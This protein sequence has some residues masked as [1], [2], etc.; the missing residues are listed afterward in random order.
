MLKACVVCGNPSD[1]GRCPAHRINRNGSTRRSRKQRQRIIQRDGY[2]CQRCGRYL[3]GRQDTHADHIVP[4]ANG[5]TWD[6]SNMQTL[7]AECNQTKGTM[8]ADDHHVYPV[9]DL[10]EHTTDGSDCICGP[11]TEPVVR[12]DGSIG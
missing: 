8:S 7:C 3:T 1:Q 5:G 10:V 4:L 9:N 11:T 12:D 2:Q 6:D